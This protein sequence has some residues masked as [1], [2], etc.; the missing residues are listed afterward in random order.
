MVG[1]RL[2][3]SVLAIAPLLVSVS[4]HAADYYQQPYQPPP[5]QPPPIIIQQPAPEFAGNW[6]LRGQIGVGM[7]Q[8][9]NIS[10]V[11]GAGTTGNFKFEHSDISD[12]VFVGGGVGYEWNSWLRFDVTGEYRSKAAITAFGSFT[13]GGGTFGDQ[14]HGSMKSWL[15]LANSYVDIGTWDCFTPFVGAGIG[16]AQNTLADFTDVGIATSGRGIGRNTSQWNFAWALYAGVTYNVTKTFKVDLT[17]RY[18][19]LGGLS[20]T[21]NCIGGCNAVTYKFKDIQSHDFMLA[22]RW[23]CC[24]F[25]PPP[26]RYVYTPPPP[27]PLQ[28]KG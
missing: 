8:A 23:A 27:P 20:D 21:I 11:R 6:Y 17:Y 7:T 28:S 2:S 25:A 18:V 22:F 14:F 5:Y 16:F 19:D 26:P 24:D 4:A 10:F 1:A 15:F 9:S 3:F 13:N 12:S